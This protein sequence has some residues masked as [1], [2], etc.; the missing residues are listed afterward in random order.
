MSLVES[1]KKFNYILLI[2]LLFRLDAFSQST[3][4]PNDDA[5]VWRHP[6]FD[7]HIPE[8][9]AVLPVDNQS[10]DPDIEK[11]LNLEISGR[12]KAKGFRIISEDRVNAVMK[13]LGVQTP[14]QLSAFSSEKLGQKLGC[15]AVL[16]GRIDQSAAIHAVVYD[17]V[18]VS[19]SM[20]LKDC[21][22]GKMLW[23]IVQK[24]TAH[25]QLQADPINLLI[26]LI[27]HENASREKRLAWLADEM[28]KTMPNGKIKI[29]TDNLLN[30]AI[31]I[32]ADE[33]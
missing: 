6:E 24:R 8:I 25:R 18:V 3:D 13:E 23:S 17:A 15:D 27:S 19:C 29:D 2:L 10:L 11:I 9:I 20:G 21:K 30:Q 14:G 33:E 4:P 31:Q 16:L 5:L 22:T 12:I 7:R 28:L 32:K 26:N 1:Y